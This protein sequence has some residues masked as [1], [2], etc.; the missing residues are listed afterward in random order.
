MPSSLLEQVDGLLLDTASCMVVLMISSNS[1]GVECTLK[2]IFKVRK[3]KMDLCD[4]WTNISETYKKYTKSF[5]IFQST[6]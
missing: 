3:I 2:V 5:M 4:I 6:S 1:I